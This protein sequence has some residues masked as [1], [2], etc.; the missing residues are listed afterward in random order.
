MIEILHGLAGSA[1]AKIVKTGDDNQTTAGLVQGKADVAEIGVRDV[2]QLRQSAGGP[3]PHHGTARVEPAVKHLHVCGGLRLLEGDVNG[4][5][6]AARERQQVGRKNHLLLRQARV[7][8]NFRRM[9]VRKEAIDLEILIHL[10]KVEIAAGVFART[11]GTGFAVAND[12]A[13][14]SDPSCLGERPQSKNHAG[15]IAAGIGNQA[16]CRNLASVKF[17]NAIDSLGEP[18]GMGSGQL[19][20]GCKSFRGAKTECAA[21]IH[22]AETRFDQRGSQFRRDL[23]RSGEKRRARA[24]RS[25]GVNGK[26]AK[27]RF[28]P[29]TEL[30]EKLGE[31]LRPIRF[32][33]VEGG[34]PDRR[35]TQKNP[36]QFETG[37]AGD[38]DDGDLASISH[39]TRGPEAAGRLTKASIFFWRESRDFLLGVMIKTVS[40]PAI[41]PAVSVNFAPSTAAARG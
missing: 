13:V 16:S 10:D 39:F 3:D 17:R 24:A 23:M 31:T 15:G 32:A 2:L 9:A 8:K 41:V 38:T 21:Q 28:A 19:V 36:R 1:F 12:A 14:R 20:P 26:C 30:R 4:G 11:T 6:N 18:F 22:D 29:A 35:V 37:I 25:D 40:S 7:V 5:K 33:K 27:R 34:R